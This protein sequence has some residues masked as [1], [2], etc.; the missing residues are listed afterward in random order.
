MSLFSRAFSGNNE[1]R[2][3]SAAN[4]PNFIP[5]WSQASAGDTQLDHAG[6]MSLTTFFACTRLLADAVSS[7]PLKAYK[8][9]GTVD[10]LLDPQPALLSNLPYPEMSWRD[11]L[12]MLVESLAVTGN[13]FCLITGRD[14][15][16]RPTALLPIH[17]RLVNV[18]QPDPEAV[19]W[20]EVIYSVAGRRVPKMD[21]VHIKRFPVAGQ[22]LGMSPIEKA[23]DAIG[24]SLDAER[25][26]RRWFKDSA[27]PSGV[28]STDQALTEQ[29][30]KQT[31]KQWLLAHRDRR[32]PA[33][34]GGGLK[35]TSISVTPE[36]SQFLQTRSFQRSE[37]AMWFGVP[38]HMIGDTEKSTSW[39][40]GIDAQ[41][42]G[43]VTFTLEPWLN[44]IEEAFS[45]LL[46][47][48]QKAEFVL[49]KLLR[50]DPAVRWEGYRQ[51]REA[52][53]YS[54]NDIRL[55]EG[56]PPIGPE[57]DIRLQPMNFVPLGTPPEK[58]LGNKTSGSAEE[59]STK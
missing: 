51:G 57:G 41:K 1:K 22:A 19:G 37:I 55:M 43:F 33:V 49:A 12:W 11:W 34:M 24:L 36:E 40:E 47:R 17:P 59:G 9:S 31:L 46:P 54:V 29:Q 8:T 21:I 25:Y 32:L 6:A 28:L 35:W 38:P 10:L 7:L 45:L 2:W 56:L 20:P 16:N 4:L 15:S 18:L 52:G 5:P 50:G 42:D 27:I 30:V 14:A 23:A 48:G 44:C 39:G 53:V 13:A 3:L 26:G 58:Y